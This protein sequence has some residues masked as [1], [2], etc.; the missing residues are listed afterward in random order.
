[1]LHK[2]IEY[3]P[4]FPRYSLGLP[5][6]EKSF[7]VLDLVLLFLTKSGKSKILMLNKIDVELRG[8]QIRLR[9]LSE[10]KS[11]RDK[12]YSELSEKLVEL[13]NLVGGIKRNLKKEAT[14][15]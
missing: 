13:G 1:V 10:T 9:I 2:K 12:P 8:I 11:L 3:L 4:K 15:E 14:E 6:L 7:A 5:T